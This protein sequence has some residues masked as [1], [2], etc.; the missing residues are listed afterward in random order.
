M[1]IY[2]YLGHNI[3]VY[4][5]YSENYSKPSRN[6]YQ[7]IIFLAYAQDTTSRY[8]LIETDF[9]SNEKN[10]VSIA[11]SSNP[12]MTFHGRRSGRFIIPL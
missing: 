12:T 4:D 6:S 5:A 10:L 2:E 8:I 3:D 9:H 11:F 1:V 7:S